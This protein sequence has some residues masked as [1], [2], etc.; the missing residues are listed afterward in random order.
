MKKSYGGA[1][2]NQDGQVLVREPTDHYDGYV[3]T[4]AKG[5]PNLGESIEETA[6]REVLEETGV[7][8]QIVAKIPG[9]FRG[10]TTDNEYFLMT[11]IEN[12]KE[13][14]DETQSVRW[15]TQS[16]ARE[17]ISNTTNVTGKIRDPRVLEAAF[18]LFRKSISVS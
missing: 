8:A 15:V 9:S 5:E 6:L 2:I 18:E 3:W 7:I 14:G 4:F 16:E 12:T 10:S 17:M 13:P 11:P 1:V